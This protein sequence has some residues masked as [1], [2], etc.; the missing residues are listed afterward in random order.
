MNPNAMIVAL[1]AASGS[2]AVADRTPHG[3][4]SEH[5]AQGR[6]AGHIYVNIA[7]GERILTHDRPTPRLRGLGGP[8]PV[9][10]A[11]NDIP[12]VACGLNNR[13]LTVVD[14]PARPVTDPLFE[15][16]TG[17]MFLDWGDIAFD[18]VVDAV[19]LSYATEHADTDSDGDG[20]PDGVE[21]FGATWSW[22]DQDDGFGD[23]CDGQFHLTSITLFDLPGDDAPG[24]G[25]MAYYTLTV[26]LVGGF[27][28][29][30][31]FEL[32]DTDLSDGAAHVW[33]GSGDD[34]DGDGLH[35]FSHSI[36]FHQPGTVDF[37]GDGMLDGNAG[38]SART[39]IMMVAPDGPIVPR[40]NQPGVFT[41][42]PVAPSPAAQGLEDAYDIYVSSTGLQAE[43]MIG[44][45]WHQGFTCDRDGSGVPGD[46][47][48]DYRPFASF[49][50]QL[51]SPGTGT[52]CPADLF[53]PP[54]GDGQLNFFDL[55]YYI[56]PLRRERPHR[57]RVP[58]RRRRGIQLLRCGGVHQRVQRGV[59]L[60][61]HLHG[62]SPSHRRTA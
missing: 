17:G 15:V 60:T 44:T 50:Q 49:Y 11:D 43:G 58:D 35:D 20:F 39:A 32:G 24:D 22:F 37:D 40:P 31:T 21:G 7:T 34:R 33:H 13:L 36:R 38:L 62:S 25:R 45:F 3:L 6:D 59:P 10:M 8:E 54:A 1:L 55:S 48:D 12:C 27:S 47:P 18:T 5:M 2:A 51:Y 19:G 41:V 29:L 23:N 9:W 26:D 14:D 52:P 28:Q 42:D 61:G 57:G 30:E 46:Q 53:P 4:G 56:A 16:R